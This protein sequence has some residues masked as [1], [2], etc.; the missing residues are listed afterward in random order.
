[1]RNDFT[2]VVVNAPLRQ[3]LFDMKL[4]S[5]FSVVEPLRQ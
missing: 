4:D 5:D 1:M 2:N 3:E